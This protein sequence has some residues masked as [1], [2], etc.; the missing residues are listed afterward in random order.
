[1]QLKCLYSVNQMMA[2]INIFNPYENVQI[3]F[4]TSKVPPPRS[5]M[6]KFTNI[7]PRSYLDFKDAVI[8]LKYRHIKGAATKIKDE[9][10]LFTVSLL[11]QAVGNSGCRRLVDNTQD[12]ETYLKSYIKRCL[13][14]RKQYHSEIEI[15]E[16][17]H[18]INFR[19]RTVN[20]TRKN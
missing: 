4:C 19:Y 2:Q 5:K 15:R 7:F 12:V 18:I 6:R 16:N 14:K 11:V 3:N 10:I 9:N 13:S 20:V 1:M 8:N 17:K